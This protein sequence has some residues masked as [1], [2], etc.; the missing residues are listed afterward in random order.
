MQT[1]F[2]VISMSI[3]KP[4]LQTIDYKKELHGQAEYR[5]YSILIM[6]LYPREVEQR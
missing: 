1:N 3:R 4:E 5:K 2:A 6:R